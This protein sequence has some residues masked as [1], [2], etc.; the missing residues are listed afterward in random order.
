MA[1]IQKIEKRSGKIEKFN[2]EKITVAIY[3]ATEAV[4]EPDYDLAEELSGKVVGNL[5]EELKEEETPTVERVQDEVEQVLI[6]N[7]HSRVA[8]AY[9]LYRRE[10]TKIRREKQ[11]LLNKKEI[12]RVDK[13]FDLNSLRVLVSRYLRKNKAGEVVESVRELFERVAV[14]TAIPSLFYDQRVFDKN[15]DFSH[16]PPKLNVEK[17]ENE[18]SI[19]RFKLNRYHLQTLLRLYERKNKKGQMKVSWPV[20]F[21]FL[22]EGKFDSYAKEVEDYF[23]LMARREFLPNTPTLVNF[24]S[25][26]GMGSACFVLDIDDDLGSIMSCLKKAAMI[27]KAGGGVGYNFSKLRPEGD[28][29][30]ST[31]GKSS[32][33][34]SFMTLFD[35]MTDVIKQG[36]VRRGASI[37][38]LDSDH[39]DIE[40][41]IKAKE[42]NKALR[43]FNISVFIKSNFWDYY[44][45][46]EP[47]PLV[48]PRTGKVVKKVNP[49]NLFDLIVYQAWESAEP[50]VI[51]EEHL[52]R[53]NSML[54]S[55]GPIKSTNPCGEIPLYPGGSCNLGSINVWSFIKKKNKGGGKE[56]E[57]DWEEFEKVI[58]VSTRFL[59]NVIDANLFPLP[60]IEKT[61][62]SMRKIALG[63]MGLGNLLFE[64]EI[65]YNSKK[66]F[67]F[68]EKLMEFMNYHSKVA[69]CELA[70]ER[71]T[72]PLYEESFYPEGKLPFRG[73][74]GELPFESGED[75]GL[76]WPGLKKM[77]KER[78][79]RN[80][81]TT[82][83][84]PTGSR[85]M[86]AG[87]SA[88][89]EPVYSLVYEKKV[90]VG[91]FYYVNPVFEKTM[92]RRGLFDDEL[93]RE[94]CEN[95]GSI[96]KLPYVSDE[97][98]DVF[99]AAMDM[100]AEAHI[101]A[102]AAFQRWTDASISKTINFPADATIE[103]MKEA[104]LLAHKLGCKDLTVFRDQ[105]IT[106]VFSAGVTEKDKEKEE[107]KEQEQDLVGLKD[108]KAKGPTIYQ[109]AGANEEEGSL[110]QDFEEKEGDD[111]NGF[112]RSAL[113][114]GKCPKCGATLVKSE[115]CENCPDC[116][117]GKC[118]V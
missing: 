91:T 96:Q 72:F 49:R 55:K 16:K 35:K 114:E 94:V 112:D 45:K 90:A 32:G 113:R 19:G 63:I 95:K 117:W 27:F 105:S 31:G 24:G 23:D 80:A 39:P 46:G 88:G 104:Y 21:R 2:P 38:I 99:V 50:G 73:R 15:G 42:G 17:A 110:G 102:L 84:A 14:N 37:G 101:K 79:V 20:F 85:A 11:Q 111:D 33:P 56:V 100:S 7:G 53:H 18:V 118:S 67:T 97:L 93:I 3:K 66:G 75:L 61:T 60:E 44:E 34:I 89:V 25:A 69:S 9:I 77:I 98:K 74:K 116:G 8:K 103:D 107:E 26:L 12:D 54:K 6:E 57:F 71:G 76:D 13:R 92:R 30:S 64:M 78:G 4:G 52:N 59:D 106:G 36:G 28:Q 82:G 58:K 40:E 5:E 70:Q 62:L 29:I 51:F 87:T 1:E 68:M 115:G 48:N 108:V 86:I 41:F 109:E 22:K 43:N 47:Y 81:H 65:P 83:H 10:R